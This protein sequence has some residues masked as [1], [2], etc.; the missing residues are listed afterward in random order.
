[1][2]VF[3]ISA[4]LVLLS[5]TSFGQLA[6]QPPTR[7]F[8]SPFT[9]KF[10]IDGY[11][12]QQT[13]GVG[14]WLSAN[15]S[16][17]ADQFVLTDALVA[18]KPL[19]YTEN[20]SYGSDDL[21]FDGSNRAE[22]NPQDAS[23]PWKWK[24]GSAINKANINHAL[25]YIS[26]DNLGDIWGMF[27]AD[28]QFA[29]GSTAID[30]EFLQN[31]LERTTDPN[32]SAQGG[33]RTEGPN[34]G[35]TLGDILIS[36]QFTGSAG[37]LLFYKWSSDGSG[38]YKYLPYNP[39]VPLDPENALNAF[40]NINTTSIDVPYLGFGANTYGANMFVEGAINL[41]KA[42]HGSLGSCA[43]LNFKTLFIKTKA[44]DDLSGN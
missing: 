23:D 40:A 29:N 1:M 8:I 24:T 9:T 11:L 19:V 34:G 18:T 6:P 36:V 14:D 3:F 21:I 37:R 44:T 38:G 28:R 31:T 32:N 15:G 4:F 17:P 30:F 2:K 12:R 20:D 33:F 35:R 5:A 13:S 39:N 16:T 22:E 10:N 27:S 26:K 7:N 42:I 41:S 25:V 43:G